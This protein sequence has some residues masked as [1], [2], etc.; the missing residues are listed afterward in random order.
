MHGQRLCGVDQMSHHSR[1]HRRRAT[2]GVPTG[3]AATKRNAQMPSPGIRTAPTVYSHDQ[4]S[5][6]T[7]L[8][9]L[10]S[11]CLHQSSIAAT[12]SHPISVLSPKSTYIHLFNIARSLTCTDRPLSKVL[13]ATVYNNN[14]QACRA[15]T[16]QASVNNCWE[17]GRAGQIRREQSQE[18]GSGT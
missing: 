13:G 4:F 17:G 2:T 14:I 10:T 7:F 15:L 18:I 3:R 16:K 5:S 8:P 1:R 6:P 9:L 11:R 12:P